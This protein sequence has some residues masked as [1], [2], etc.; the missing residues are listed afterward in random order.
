MTVYM[1]ASLPEIPYTHRIYMV[2][3]NPNVTVCL[4]QDVNMLML[5]VRSGFVFASSLECLARQ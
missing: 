1:E 4:Q 2:L 3:A 5:L